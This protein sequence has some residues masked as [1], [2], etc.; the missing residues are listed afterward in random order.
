M[1]RVACGAV[2]YQIFTEKKAVIV[3]TYR[4]TITLIRWGKGKFVHN[5]FGLIELNKVCNPHAKFVQKLMM[6]LV[7]P[8][9]TSCPVLL[10]DSQ[11]L[12]CFLHKTPNLNLLCF[13]SPSNPPL[14]PHS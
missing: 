2:M 10:I 13:F 8:F 3:E 7:C 14:S 6:E 4:A 12:S 9:P 1:A 5:S 11:L